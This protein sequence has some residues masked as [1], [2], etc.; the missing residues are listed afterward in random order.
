MKY[1]VVTLNSKQ[2][3]VVE[4]EEIFLDRIASID[5]KTVDFDEVLLVVDGKSVKVGTPGVKGAKVLAEVVGEEKGKKVSVMKY[6][7]KSRYRRKTGH[8]PVYTRVKITKVA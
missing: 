6:N 1:A 8:R 7:A 3:K 5:Q 2:Y 4:G